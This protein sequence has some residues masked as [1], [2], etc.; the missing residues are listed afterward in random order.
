MGRVAA[1]IKGMGPAELMAF[2]KE[3]S[4]TLEGHELAAGDI[5]VGGRGYRCVWVWVCVC[6]GGWVGCSCASAVFGGMG[7]RVR[8]VYVHTI[9]IPPQTSTIDNHPSTPPPQNQKV[10]HDFKAPEG[11]AAEDIDAAGGW[12]PISHCHT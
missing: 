6:V 12:R 4:V 5:K 1:A 11:V 3:G 9:S 7:A 10:L 8:V 2:E